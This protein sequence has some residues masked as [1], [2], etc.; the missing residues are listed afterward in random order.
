[1]FLDTSCFMLTLRHN[2]GFTF[3]FSLPFNSALLS[4]ASSHSPS[5]NNW[6]LIQCLSQFSNY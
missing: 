3:Y 4:V 6:K 2:S 1:M 5:H